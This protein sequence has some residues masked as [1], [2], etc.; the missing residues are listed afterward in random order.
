MATN[1]SEPC[2]RPNGTKLVRK[3]K[4]SST[5]VVG[6]LAKFGGY[7]DELDAAGDDDVLGCFI[8]TGPG[9]VGTSYAGNAA[10]TVT[11]E[12]HALSGGIVPVLVG[13]TGATRGKQARYTSGAFVDAANA[14]PAGA[15]NIPLFGAFTESGVSGDYVGLSVNYAERIIT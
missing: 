11:V 13:S 9:P 8:V 2:N 1:F 12:V 7:D 15:T 4:N 6:K 5:L 14:A 3:V 10:G